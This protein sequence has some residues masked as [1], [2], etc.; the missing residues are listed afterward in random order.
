M[1]KS[2]KFNWVKWVS[3]IV[4]FPLM[5]FG[6]IGGWMLKL[7]G[8]GQSTTGLATWSASIA[9]LVPA[10]IL[11]LVSIFYWS[12]GIL[13]R[14]W[15]IW[16]QHWVKNVMWALLAGIIMM[17]VLVPLT[18]ALTGFLDTGDFAIK[19]SGA[20]ALSFS[21]VAPTFLSAIVGLFAP[22]YEEIVF[23]HAITEPFRNKA[24]WVYVLLSIFANIMFG[25]VHI[26]NVNGHWSSLIMYIVMGV[27]LQLVYIWGGRNIWQNIMTHM[28]YNGS[29]SLLM[30]FSVIIT[31]FF[32]K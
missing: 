2:E 11:L 26:N 30:I 1:A 32:G 10:T 29:I 31:M 21:D 16:R 22:F 8:N 12:D 4:I 3:A 20:S 14:D 19:Y 7:M 25:V 28:V 15:Q 6:P 23:H 9:A 24:K 5:V 18:K 27:W 13:R 17:G